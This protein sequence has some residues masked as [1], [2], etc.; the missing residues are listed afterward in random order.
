[1]LS[2][3]GVSNCAIG[4]EC[5]MRGDVVSS[6]F[7]AAAA[8]LCANTALLSQ[9]GVC[10]QRPPFCLTKVRDFA[11]AS[12]AASGFVELGVGVVL[13]SRIVCGIGAASCMV[14]SSSAW[15]F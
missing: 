9:P 11:R 2:H 7:A 8:T 5:G 6:S 14:S 3:G 15:Q 12:R 10:V 1:M 4:R 13:S